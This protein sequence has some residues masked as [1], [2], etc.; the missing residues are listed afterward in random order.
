MTREEELLYL[1]DLLMQAALWR[2]QPDEG[3]TPLE[4]EVLSRLERL[5]AEAASELLNKTDYQALEAVKLNEHLSK[6]KYEDNSVRV[7]V[8]GKK[9]R[10]KRELCVQVPCKT[11]PTGYKWVLKDSVQDS[12]SEADKLSNVDKLSDELWEDHE[13]GEDEGIEAIQ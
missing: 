6:K 2:V 9:V 10:M 5:K 12:K 3:R 11:S 13:R 8:D 1:G 4:L 7:M